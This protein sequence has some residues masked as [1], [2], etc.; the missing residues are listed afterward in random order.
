MILCL[1]CQKENKTSDIFDSDVLLHR[2]LRSHKVKVNEYY[3]TNYGKTDLFT[4]ELLPF[5]NTESYFA[6]DF[7]NRKN[8][9]DYLINVPA[10]ELKGELKKIFIKRKKYKNLVYSPSQ[11]ELKSSP[12]P[13]I[14]FFKKNNIDYNHF[15]KE[16]NLINKFDYNINRLDFD[17]GPMEWICDTREQLPLKFTGENV[18]VSGLNFGDYTC[19]SHF[20]NIFIDRKSASDFIGT[21][22]S[23]E[24]F[25]KEIQR[26][27]ELGSYLIII[28]EVGLNKMLNF[29]KEKF[30]NKGIKFKPEF[31][32]HNVKDICQK[33]DNVQ[34][35]FTNGRMEMVEVI[36]KIYLCKQDIRKMDLQFVY[37]KG[38]LV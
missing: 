22:A 29:N 6:N 15:S 35:L 34:F 3:V 27:K 32:F 14:Q 30:L 24:R 11:V 37:E 31:I 20:K 5:K 33:Y 10:F 2:H 4:K 18:I 7:L 17:S 36:R 12:L 1:E 8:C 25:E 38:Y 21:F 28:C 16:L 26:A 9:I 13:N 23:I 19:K